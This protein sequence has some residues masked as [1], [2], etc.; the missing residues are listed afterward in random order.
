MLAGNSGPPLQIGDW[1]LDPSVDTISRGGE[2]QK[3]EPRTTRLLLLLAESPGA[4]ISVERILT[5]VWAGVIVGPASAYQAV[6]R[7]RRLLGDTDPNPTYIATVP[8]KGYRL[9]APVRPAA[10]VLPQ[11]ASF[12][13]GASREAPGG[14]ISVDTDSA[15]TLPSGCVSAPPSGAVPPGGVPSDAVP[16]GVVRSGGAM[17]GATPP[18]TESPQRPPSARP[19][20]WGSLWPLAAAAVAIVVT[21]LAWFELGG[22]SPPAPGPTSVV[23]L[24]FID[25]TVEK[26]DQ[27]FCDG[28]T[29]ELSNWLAQ[30]P[31]LRVVARTSAFSYLGRAVDVRTIGKELGATHVLEGSLRRSGAQLRVTAQLINTRD[32]FH[33]WSS[34][35]D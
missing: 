1:V 7:L 26:R 12:F 21:A 19:R 28:L 18:S 10:R 30:I 25:M 16:S 35:F 22:R 11:P 27:A 6:S 3:L 31:T 8:R 5:E 34:T 33:I 4:V 13:A 14:A 2:I 23:V 29:E 17:P 32:G 9:V 15:G 24:P 20:T